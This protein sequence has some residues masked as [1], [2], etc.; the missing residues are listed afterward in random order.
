MWQLK[1][2]QGR[3]MDAYKYDRLIL[4]PTYKSKPVEKE[5]FEQMGLK[6]QDIQERGTLAKTLSPIYKNLLKSAGGSH[7]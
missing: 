3:A 2:L 5:P 6:Q 7:L 1:T 4:L